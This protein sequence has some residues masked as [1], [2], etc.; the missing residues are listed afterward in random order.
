MSMFKNCNIT[1]LFN[2]ILNLIVFIKFKFFN[3]KLS[4]TEINVA[5]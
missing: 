1:L 4:F 5:K 3:Y 2:F